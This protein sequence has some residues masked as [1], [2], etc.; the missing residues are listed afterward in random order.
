MAKQTSKATDN[1]NIPESV[2]EETPNHIMIRLDKRTDKTSY[3][4]I[5]AWLEFRNK[6]VKQWVLEQ[7]DRII[8]ENPEEIVQIFQ[9]KQQMA[10]L[11][12]QTSVKA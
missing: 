5:K 3:A 8:E 7:A 2:L 9:L 10:D 6:T 4:V 11:K 12:E 1:L